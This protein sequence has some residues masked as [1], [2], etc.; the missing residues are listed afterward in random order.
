MVG[1]TSTS[2][3]TDHC[4]GLRAVR[5][6]TS[7][8]LSPATAGAVIGWWVWSR[9]HVRTT[10]AYVVGNITPVSSEIG[11]QVV[12]LYADDNMIVSAGAP[13]AQLDPGPVP[14]R[15]RSAAGR[16]AQLAGGGPRGRGERPADPPGSAGPPGRRGWRGG[17]RPSGRPGRRRL[18]WRHAGRSTTKSRSCWAR[19]GAGARARR[20]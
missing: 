3:R 5:L 15:G 7:L 11:G 20:A 16:P 19:S 6:G 1:G 14:A 18:R 10:N 8:G 2:P 9:L 4:A 12:A 17:A 13:L